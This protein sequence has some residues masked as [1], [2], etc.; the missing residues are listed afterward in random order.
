MPSAQRPAPSH[1]AP[2]SLRQERLPRKEAAK[3]AFAFAFAFHRFMM[4]SPQ[5]DRRLSAQE[6]NTR[7]HDL[8]PVRHIMFLLSFLAV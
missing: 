4:R 8:R 5:P 1:S 3:C 6:Q 2:P 7:Q